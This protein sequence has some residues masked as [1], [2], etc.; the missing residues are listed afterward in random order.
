MK[1]P[2][3]AIS[4]DLL[5][6]IYAQLRAAAQNQKNAERAGHTLSATANGRI[7]QKFSVL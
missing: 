7:L 3:P 1:D 2:D 6:T 5:A 4:P